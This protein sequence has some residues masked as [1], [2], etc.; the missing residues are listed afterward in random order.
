MRFIIAL[1]ITAACFGQVRPQSGTVDPTGVNWLPPTS[2][3]AHPPNS[4]ATGSAY[5][6]TDARAV[7]TCSGGGVALATCRWTGRTWSAVAF[8]GI[9]NNTVVLLGDS[10]TWFNMPMSDGFGGM[11]TLAYGYFTW[12][13]VLLK[14]AFTVVNYAGVSGDTTA[15][16]L[17][18][19]STDV[20]AYN[21]G[22]CFVLAGTNDIATGVSS[23]TIIANLKAIYTA[24]NAA[25][26]KTVMLTILP[27]QRYATDSGKRLIWSTVN[28]WMKE[29]AKLQNNLV[30][31]DAAAAIIDPTAATIVPR[32]N[33]TSDGT[34]PL[35]LGA[36]LI[37]KAITSSLSSIVIPQATLPVW[38]NDPLNLVTNGFQTGTA[39]TVTGGTGVAADGWTLANNGTTCVGSKD[40]RSDGLGA[41]QILT[42]TGSSSASHCDLTQQISGWSA[43]D[44]IWAQAEILDGTI[45]GHSIALVIL[46]HGGSD[47]YYRALFSE[48]NYAGFGGQAL[49]N[50]VIRTTYPVYIPT[51][52]STVSVGVYTFG[53]TGAVKIGRIEVRRVVTP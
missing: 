4:P 37:G 35:A 43:G 26:I 38:N 18:R 39:G 32:A 14:Q 12:A 15:G 47:V 52:V 13:N 20:L 33:T 8:P 21:P 42:M 31:V 41:V 46:L 19:V 16:M 2:T 24:L 1:L 40:T 3:F 53:T 51:G 10:I 27:D 25:G 6:F 9:T 45:V 11:N 7:G 17:A 48:S 28:L 36:Y 30:L 5:I 22:W 23:A 50:M 29:W 44:T 34:H 49:P